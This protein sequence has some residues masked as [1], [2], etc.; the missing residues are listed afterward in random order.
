VRSVLGADRELTVG[1]RGRP[2]AAGIVRRICSKSVVDPPLNKVRRD[3]QPKHRLFQSF[4]W[5]E[6]TRH[7][8]RAYEQ[9]DSALPGD[10]RSGIVGSILG[11][12][13]FLIDLFRFFGWPDAKANKIIFFYLGLYNLTSFS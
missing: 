13:G 1:L 7:Y 11:C 4:R 12:L 5:M 6:A 9:D 3:G 2:D 10:C 8:F